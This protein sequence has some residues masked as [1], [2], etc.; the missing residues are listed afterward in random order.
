MVGSLPP[1]FYMYNVHI[2]RTPVE[3]KAILKKLGIED[4]LKKARAV[5]QGRYNYDLAVYK[6]SG[7][8]ITIQ[9]SVHGRFEQTPANHYKGKGCP[10]CRNSKLAK[11][12]KLKYTDLLK[13]LGHLESKGLK[14]PFL[15]VEYSNFFSKVSLECPRHG[16]V[17]VSASNLLKGGGCPKCG[18]DWA[19]RQRAKGR[20]EFIRQAAALHG[21]R[22]DYSCV[23]YVSNSIPVTIICPEHGEFKQRP[24]THIRPGAVGGAAGC[25]KC[26]SRA[27]TL[28]QLED[29]STLESRFR[30]KHGLT[31][32]RY[33]LT[34]Y[35]GMK[36]RVS[37]LCPTHGWF[38]QRAEIHLRGN[39]CVK[40]GRSYTQMT[41][42][43][44]SDA[45]RD[46]AEHLRREGLQVEQDATPFEGSRLEVDVYVPSRR[47]GVEFNGNWYHSSKYKA[48]NYHKKKQGLAEASGIRLIQLFTDEW[49][50]RKEVCKRTLS[51]LAGVSGT[52]GGARD[53]LLADVDWKEAKA[54][55]ELNHLQGA[56]AIGGA[57][58]GL[59][60]KVTGDLVCLMT[61]SSKRSQRGVGVEE[62]VYELARY[63]AKGVVA[64]A[65]SRLFS[66]LR[67]LRGDVRKVT[68]YS[69][70]RWFTG[71]MYKKLGFV[72][73]GQTQPNYTYVQ[74]GDTVRHNKMGFQKKKLQ[75]RMGD[76]YDP[77]KTEKELCEQLGYYRVYDCGLTRWEWSCQ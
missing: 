61:L 67:T 16:V 48:S 17:R 50:H 15:E 62:G 6:G 45:Q 46:I 1:S 37:I 30:D 33:N 43:Y 18:A 2:I 10:L 58:A 27:R 40:C 54:F 36:T 5:H 74:A 12:R 35:A 59:R 44:G 63:A 56:G 72:R 11:D 66:Y 42:Q 69:D 76:G 3:A 14:V 75:V 65:A 55:Y 47:F 64:G 32:T 38:K 19:L 24:S 31:Y 25:R 68:S 8:K 7:E 71:G 77:A 23:D 49:V 41:T 51:I 28:S 39:G 70:N 13:R 60:D 34:E 53:Y 21:N 26:L 4:F 57:H 52:L 9:C 20:D 29:V 22:Y 73:V